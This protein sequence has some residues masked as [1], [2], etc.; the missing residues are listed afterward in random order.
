MAKQ[1]TLAELARDFEVGV[2]YLHGVFEQ[3]VVH[4]QRRDAE[5]AEISKL[6]E[7]L[8]KEL[9]AGRAKL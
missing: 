5:Y 9:E 6:V 2:A 7:E 3:I 1:R 4:E 8:R